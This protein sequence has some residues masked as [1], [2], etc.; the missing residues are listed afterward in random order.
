MSNRFLLAALAGGVVVFLVG[1]VF[2]GVLAAS[3]FEANQGSAV[4]AIKVAPDYV[5]LVL[6]QL[7][8][9]VYLAIVMDKWAQAGGVATGL[10]IGA[11]SGLLIGLGY[12]LTLFGTTN[13]ANLTATLVD[14]LIA[15]VQMAC[16]GA[17]I[18]AVLGDRK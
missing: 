10:K 15:M 3:F 11:I 7:V 9:G 18:G 2:Y 14:P 13:M 5:H 1:G 6:G 17:A 4:G 8:L 12:D 16:A